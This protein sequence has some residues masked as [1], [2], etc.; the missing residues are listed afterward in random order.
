M[1]Q[2]LDVG[3][4]GQGQNALAVD[5]LI[6][7]QVAGDHRKPGIDDPQKRLNLDHFGHVA[8]RGQKFVESAGLGFI[9]RDAQTDLQLVPQRGP[10][11]LRTQAAQHTQTLHALQAPGKGAGGDARAL[12]QI[13]GGQFG[14]GLIL[15]QYA[16][17]NI[18]K[19]EFALFMENDEFF[20]QQMR[21]FY[22]KRNHYWPQ[23]R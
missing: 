23:R 16:P 22:E 10:M 2:R 21:I 5:L 15:A 14:G 11:H 1:H 13:G 6:M 12:G 3:D 18:I 7:R 4:M 8:G 19:H 17:I 20:F 9:Q